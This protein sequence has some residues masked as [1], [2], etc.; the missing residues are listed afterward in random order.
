M[1]GAVTVALTLNSASARAQEL[2]SILPASIPGY[3]TPFGVINI[4]HPRRPE[5]TGF[6][7]GSLTLIPQLELSQGYDSAPNGS[8]G[9]SLFSAAPSLV[10]TDPL[11]GFGAFAAANI[12]RLPQNNAQNTSGGAVVFGERAVLPRETITIAA[13]YLN[14]QE[15]GFALDTIAI[16]RPV[17]F[18]MQDVHASDEIS[19][20]M[21]KV[22]PELSATRYNFPS[23]S[24]Q[25]RTDT[26]EGLTTSYLPGGPVQFVLRLRATQSNYSEA[27]FN[28][29]TNQALAGL[30]DTANG[31]WTFSALAGLAQ[32]QPRYG[33]ALTAPVLEAG[34]DWIPGD[35]DRLRLTIAHEIDDPDE[36]SATPY[37]L[38]QA[39]LTLTHEYLN[40]IIFILAAQAAN[41]SY[42]HSPL[43]ETL[44]SSDANISW[45]FGARL[46]LNGDYT[47]N[48]RQAN[49][50]RAANEHIITLGVT[51]TP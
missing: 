29:D 9:S 21:F 41:A 8:S 49:Y 20:G 47:F 46:A 31:L 4:N 11:L 39:K 40:N 14:T 15:T 27:V 5:V 22:K 1:T 45:Q 36:V 24:T 34:L 32:R 30:I 17:P 23:L 37:T 3:A 26:R 18:T 50:L 48:D 33:T 10:V 19:L 42:I 44:Y 35:L 28:A 12:A 6:Q 25:D 13:G 38:T 51:W 7:L 2:E 43:R 16:S